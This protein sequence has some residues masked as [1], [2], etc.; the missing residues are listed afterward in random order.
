MKSRIA[1]TLAVG[2]FAVSA[3]ASAQHRPGRHVARMSVEDAQRI[4]LARVPGQVRHEE[5][6]FENHRWIYSF[7]ISAG[8]PGIEEVNIDADTGAIVEVVHERN[9]RP[10]FRPS[11]TS[12]ER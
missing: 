2:A 9:Q 8:R 11:A 4:A 6:E 12:Q 7:E 3:L 1:L 10:L 5:M